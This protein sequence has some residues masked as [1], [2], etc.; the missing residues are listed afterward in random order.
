MLQLLN[1]PNSRLPLLLQVITVIYSLLHPPG[2]CQVEGSPLLLLPLL[3]PLLQPGCVGQALGGIK[4]GPPAASTTATAT[5]VA[6]TAARLC[7]ASTQWHGD[8]LFLNIT[9]LD[10]GDT[11]VVPPCK[12]VRGVT[13]TAATTAT[14]TTTAR[15]CGAGTWWHQMGVPY[16]FCHCYCYCCCY[17]RSQAVWGKHSVAW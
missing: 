11:D 3:L 17:Y 8:R 14:A 4:W 13:P 10:H 9:F 2:L 15:L 6:T 16:C 7:G 5:A 1:A 12:L